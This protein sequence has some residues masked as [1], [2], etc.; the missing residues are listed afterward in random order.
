MQNNINETNEAI[1]KKIEVSEKDIRKGE[2]I[3]VEANTNIKMLQDQYRTENKKLTDLG[4]DPKKEDEEIKKID[5]EISILLKEID[6]DI[7]TDLI[8]KY[9]NT[10]SGSI[11]A[12]VTDF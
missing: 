5:E 12:E 10:G 1:L 9:R 7:P 3:R 8:S 4:I 6:A 2:E 11:F